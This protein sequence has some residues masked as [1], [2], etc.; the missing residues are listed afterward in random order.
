M[1]LFVLLFN[2]LIFFVMVSCFVS[3]ALHGLLGSL[4]LTL[5]FILAS[6]TRFVESLL[7]WS[8]GLRP[9]SIEESSRVDALFR[10]LAVKAH[11]PH[12]P[13]L[14]IA[15][16]SFP[17]AYAI[18]KQTVGL[19]KGLLEKTTNEELYGVL[20]HEFGHLKHGDSF[21]YSITRILNIGGILS[22]WVI[23]HIVK[24]QSYHLLPSSMGFLDVTFSGSVAVIY[25]LT[26]LIRWY[27][28]AGFRVVGPKEE[29][30]ADSFVAEV[31]GGD[32]F[33]SFLN[34]S[35]QAEVSWNRSFWE[36]VAATHPPVILRIDRIKGHMKELGRNQGAR[37]NR[38]KSCYFE[39]R[40]KIE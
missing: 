15:D 14:F 2:G 19:T 20:A 28:G 7:L 12:P 13:R 35:T 36:K 22:A 37:D 5:L 11:L 23:L 6:H 18:G 32:G 33:I 31:G 3:S 34:R 4:I 40:G 26:T 9:A 17:N 29:Y 39:R 38:R 27:F 8:S 24:F 30:R 10:E 1:L 25:L 16:S 21:R